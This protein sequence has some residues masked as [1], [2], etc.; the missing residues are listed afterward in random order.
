MYSLENSISL[1][2]CWKFF[3]AIYWQSIEKRKSNRDWKLYT[4]YS[5]R[6]GRSKQDCKDLGPDDYKDGI[7][8]RKKD[9][10]L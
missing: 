9:G 4:E 7:N 1:P 10:S 5:K 8:D 3:I 6:T 2:I